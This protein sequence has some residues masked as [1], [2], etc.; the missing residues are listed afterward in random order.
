MQFKRDSRGDVES[1]EL[2]DGDDTLELFDFTDGSAA[3]Q[4]SLE[5]YSEGG[6]RVCIYPNRDEVE[7]L[8]DWLT[9]VLNAHPATGEK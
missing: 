7:Q 1:H 9:E 3:P 4:V 6:E 5:C 2:S 8:R